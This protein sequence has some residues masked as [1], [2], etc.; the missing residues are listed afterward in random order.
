MI[1]RF[2]AEGGEKVY[3]CAVGVAGPVVGGRSHVVNLRWAVDEKKLARSLEIRHVRV[4][5]D[6]EATAWGIPVLPPSKFANLTPG[7]RRRPGNAALIAAGTGLGT[8]ILF[9]DGERHVPSPGEG[10]HQ[11]FAPRDDL[12][13]ELLRYMHERIGRVS[14]ERVVAGPGL[15]AIYQFLI[16]SGRGRESVEMSRRL[17][18]GDPNAV[19][20]DAGVNGDDPVAERAVELFVSLYGAVAGDLALV[21][22]ATGG[23]YVGGGIAPKILPKL[24]AGAFLQSFRAKGRLS[25]LLE[26]IPV[27][28]ILEPRTALLGAAAAAAGITTSRKRARPRLQR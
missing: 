5:N 16:D 8:T 27:K 4:L 15:S 22:R 9:W 7:L 10:G 13:I 18:Q 25:P 17:A 11:S 2:L 24:R 19:V 23:L 21:A 14:V 1:R 6:M 20:S 28:V 3:R 26:E 12:E